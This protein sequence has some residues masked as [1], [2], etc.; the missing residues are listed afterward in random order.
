[1][2]LEL[3]DVARRIQILLRAHLAMASFFFEGWLCLT[4]ITTCNHKHTVYIIVN[5]EYSFFSFPSRNKM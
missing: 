2:R 1:M 3:T 5:I 4:V